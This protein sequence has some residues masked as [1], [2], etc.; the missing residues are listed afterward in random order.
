MSRKFPAICASSTAVVPSRREQPPRA[1]NAQ[2]DAGRRAGHAAIVSLVVLIELRIRIQRIRRRC[3]DH[4]EGRPAPWNVGVR[5]VVVAPFP[6]GPPVV[7]GDLL[8]AVASLPA[9]AAL[10][11]RGSR[12][13]NSR[14][15]FPVFPVCP[16]RDLRLS[17]GVSGGGRAAHS[18]FAELR[19]PCVTV[20]RQCAVAAAARGLDAHHTNR[21]TRRSRRLSPAGIRRPNGCRS[22]R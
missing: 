12:P 11:G 17:A 15:M 14:V 13:P 18:A 9:I 8:V 3:R 4:G 20:F 19:E 7:E 22:G 1:E 16:M 5:I 2:V 6:C 10:R 21:L